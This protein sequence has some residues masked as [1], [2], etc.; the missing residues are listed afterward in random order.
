MLP[1]LFSKYNQ[2]NFSKGVLG[3]MTFRSQIPHADPANSTEDPASF[4]QICL[5]WLFRCLPLQVSDLDEIN[6]MKY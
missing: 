6:I 5:G 1:V 2:L 4:S 3:K